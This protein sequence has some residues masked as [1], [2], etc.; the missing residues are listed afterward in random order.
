MIVLKSQKEL[1]VMRSAGQ[2]VAEVFLLIKEIAKPGIT[3]ME[4]NNLA[5]K[6]I[7]KRKAV[8]AFKG[9]NGYPYTLCC[10][11]NAQIVHGMPSSVPLND[12]DIISLDL[13]AKYN[14]F[15][16]DSAITLPIGSIS[17]EA[18]Q[19]LAVTEESL[20]KGM[21]F[22]SPGN[23]LT[24]I[25]HGV[26]KYVESSG[27]SVVRDY[28][29]HGVGRMLHEAPQIPN[30]GAP[31]RGPLLKPGMVL[32]IEPMVNQFSYEVEVLDDGW[33]AVTCDGGLSAHFEHT[34]AITDN[35]PEILT[36][37]Q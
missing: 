19:L 17:K 36:A 37:I 23:R 30:Y 26:Q 27:F 32:A 29:G 33:T 7:I 20:Y 16:G 21:E 12:G 31:G 14:G 3:S 18:K 28:V 15:Y 10:S 24:D 25:S 1:A 2:I 35:G 9:Y 4:L 8:P 22:A 6:E 13:G 34:V 11:L 5:E